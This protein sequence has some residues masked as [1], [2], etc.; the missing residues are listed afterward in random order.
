[1]A[2]KKPKGKSTSRARHPI[3]SGKPRAG[4]AGSGGSGRRPKPKP[5]TTTRPTQPGKGEQNAMQR[6]KALALRK[7][8]DKVNYSGGLNAASI[9]NDKTLEAH[10]K[11]RLLGMLEKKKHE[12]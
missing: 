2:T 6:R 5:K 10:E 11:K 7:A 4:E 3:S 12:G 1:M 8:A 9:K